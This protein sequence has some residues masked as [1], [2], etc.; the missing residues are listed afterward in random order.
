MLPNQDAER[1]PPD[2][3]QDPPLFTLGFA[4]GFSNSKDSLKN[5]TDTG[6]CT[7]NIISEHFIEAANACA[8]NAPYGISEWAL[9]GLHPAPSTHV[10]SQ[11]VK[12]AIFSVEGKLL[13]AQEFESRQTPGKKTGVLAV[14]EGV[15]FWVRD[16]AI[17]EERNI[18]DPKVLRPMSRLGG[19][20]YARMTEGI[21]IPRLD[22]K[23]ERSKERTEVLEKPRADT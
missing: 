16:D 17:N 20:S 6:E 4:G 10:K 3:P 11:R 9:T 5:L 1:K 7:I 14:V 18:V 21:E 15:N 19:I 12:E 2:I 22:W 23:T 8:I 13:S